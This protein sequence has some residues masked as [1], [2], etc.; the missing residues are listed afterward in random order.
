[1]TILRPL[2]AAA[3][4]LLLAPALPMAAL[5]GPSGSVSIELQPRTAQEARAMRAGLIAYSLYRGVE[6]GAFVDQNGRLNAAAV[7]Q[8]GRGNRAVV[9]QHG[10]SHTATLDQRG[11]ANAYGIFQIGRGQT[12]HVA[13]HGNG[14]A[15][16]L[17]QVGF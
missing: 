11:N 14:G 13:Q 3:L 4:G 15:G 17:V 7:A 2:R 6:G 8:A 1:M 5:A 10:S 9:E 16:I 12:A